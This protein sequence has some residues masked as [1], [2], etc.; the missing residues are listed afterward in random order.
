MKKS[1]SP[2]RKLYIPTDRKSAVGGYREKYARR[3]LT[4]Y[5][6]FPCA[7]ALYSD[8]NAPNCSE[9]RFFFLRSRYLIRA[10]SGNCFESLRVFRRKPAH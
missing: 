7:P 3:V 10:I 9:P 1:V 2:A 6:L 5:E 8:I 4:K